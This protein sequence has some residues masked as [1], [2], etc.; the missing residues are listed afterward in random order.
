MLFPRST[1]TRRSL[2]MSMTK[3]SGPDREH[4]GMPEE[5]PDKDDETPSRPLFFFVVGLNS[6]H[7]IVG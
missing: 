2:N 7:T 5:T 1:A 4:C 6:F 3:N